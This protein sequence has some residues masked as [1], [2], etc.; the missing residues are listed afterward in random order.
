MSGGRTSFVIDGFNVYHSL[1]DASKALGLPDERGTKWLNLRALCESYLPLF[2]SDATLAGVHYFAVRT[3]NRLYPAKEVCFA[4][5]WNR[6]HEELANLV[7]RCISI[8]RDA[9]V[10]HQFPDPVVFGKRRFSKPATW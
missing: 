4:F 2:G 8:T 6:K 10:R 5:P 1:V 9:Y 7:T 3:A